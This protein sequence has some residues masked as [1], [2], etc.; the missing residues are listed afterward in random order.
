MGATL[1]LMYIKGLG[2]DRDTK[3]S[4][5]HS[6]SSTDHPTDRTN[7]N[8]LQ[9]TSRNIHRL[10]PPKKSMIDSFNA[11]A[12]I[13]TQAK[14]EIHDGDIDGL[15]DQKDYLAIEAYVFTSCFHIYHRAKET[16]THSN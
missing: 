13:E 15:V 16:G 3:G 10:A 8:R 5:G 11:S 2:L 9:T 7:R 4:R 12:P 14:L 1:R 6:T